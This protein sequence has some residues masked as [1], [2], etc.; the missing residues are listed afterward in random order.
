VVLLFMEGVV[1]LKWRL[2]PQRS[3]GCLRLLYGGN[4]RFATYETNSPMTSTDS[5]VQPL[6][7][8]PKRADARRNY[9]KLIA[10][11][12]EAFTEDGRGASLEDIARRAGV[13]I[14]TLYRHFPSRQ[15]LLVAVYVEE[16]DALCRS[17]VDLAN[18]PPWEA[19][20]AWL[21]R[22][23][24]YLATKQALAEELLAYSDT[25][26]DVFK[27]CRA[28]MYAGGEPLLRRAQDEHVVRA[29][30]DITEVIQLVGGIAKIQTAEPAQLDRLLDMAL[31][32][33]RYQGSV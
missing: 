28:A 1:P 26:A 13:G 2:P 30:T 18:Q 24:G 25:Q 22:F 29:D 8:R 15:A 31:D 23:V 21:H 11:G 27:S 33:L 10:A 14:G 20:V 3:G 12:R 19:L 9:D 4:L 7:H 32:G 6:S 17:A 5:L 16:V